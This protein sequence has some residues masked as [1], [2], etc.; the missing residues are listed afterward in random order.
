MRKEPSGIKGLLLRL[1][2]ALDDL[3]VYDYEKVLR[4]AGDS[5]SADRLRFV[6]AFLES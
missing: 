2:M 6:R 4:V 5:I 3:N 1:A